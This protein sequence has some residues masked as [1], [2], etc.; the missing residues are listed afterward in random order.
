MASPVPALCEAIDVPIASGQ[1][2]SAAINLGGR[3][4]CGFFIPAAWTAAGLTFQGSPDGVTF[5]D[6]WDATAEVTVAAV[7]SR[8]VSADPLKFYGLNYIKVRSG[9]GAS[10]VS[11]AGARVVTIMAADPSLL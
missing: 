5:V 9:T 3:I 1:S 8:Y 2:L 6:V 7:V 11:Q 4:P 10:A